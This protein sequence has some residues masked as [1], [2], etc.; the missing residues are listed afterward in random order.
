MNEDNILFV[1]MAQAELPIIK[2]SNRG[3]FVLWGESNLYPLHLI[4]YYQRSSLHNAIIKSKVNDINGDGVA[5]EG[6]T[7]KKT[8]AFIQFVNEDES[9]DELIKKLAYDLV[10]FG[11][12]AIN[13]IWSKDRNSISELY[14]IDF[15]N[16]RCGKMDER[17]RINEYYYSEDWS[18][19]KPEYVSIPAF[20][21]NK[22]K[23]EPS[24][25]LYYSSY[26]PGLKYYPLPSYIGSSAAI[27]TQIEIDNFHLAHIKNGMTPNILINFPNG[28]PTGEERRKIER[29]IRDKYVG[30]DNA[31]KFIITF[32]ESPDLAPTITT[33]SASQLDKQFLQLEQTVLQNILSGHGVVSPLLVGIPT[34]VGLGGTQII[35]DSWELYHNRVINPFKKDILTTI[36]KIMAINK[37]KELSINTSSPVSFNFSEQT[38]LQILTTNELREMIGYDP[39]EQEIEPETKPIAPETPEVGAPEASVAPETQENII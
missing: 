33:L 25:L 7:D 13:V 14:H 32:S 4:E 38:L 27:E 9:M 19:Y 17:K 31:G 35:S 29:Q 18:K 26:N 30:T 3:E 23:K 12:Y 22:N 28:V 5:Y 34:A 6:K 10:V 36:N 8:D 11:G 21:I 1:S 2:E 16:I 24:Q 39:I 37:M 20:N 15:A